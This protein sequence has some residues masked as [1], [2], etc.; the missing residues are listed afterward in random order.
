[1]VAFRLRSSLGLLAGLV[2][3]ASSCGDDGASSSG[4]GGAGS[5]SAATTGA[6]AGK[7][8]PVTFEV[9]PGAPVAGPDAETIATASFEGYATTAA[10]TDALVAAG[11]TLGVIELGAMGATPLPLVGNEPDLPAEVGLVRAMVPFDSGVLVASDTGL[12]VAKDG[13]VTR[14]AGHAEL[15]PLGLRA[16]AARHVDDDGDG[17]PDTTLALAT[18]DGLYLWTPSTLERWSVEGE[19]GA[20][21]AAFATKTTIHVAWGERVYELDRAEKTGKPVEH[22]LGAVRAI[23]CSTL[24]CGEGAVVYFA[25]S[26]GLVERSDDGKHT[27]Y[28]L[29]EEGESEVAVE[30]FAFDGQRQRLFAVTASEVVRART[31]GV[32]VHVAPRTPSTFPARLTTD[33]LGDLWVLSESEATKLATGTPLSFATDVQPIMA[34][35]C[36]ACHGEGKKGAPK[37]E[38]ES[39]AFMKDFVGT[40]I[41]R[42]QDGSMPPSGYPALPPEPLQILLDWSESKAP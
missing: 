39:Y 3:G 37:L 13:I 11:T 38:L 17:A 20:P 33:K 5:T 4:A 40:A 29:A 12:Y 31:A 16:I 41:G 2:V 14:S 15:D 22:P 10:A 30:G 36:A 24:A 28:T 35:Y 42:I 26:R 6:G 23:A 19:E 1:M 21:S 9:V 34:A 27:L 18:D 7:P 8:E 32:P 25:T